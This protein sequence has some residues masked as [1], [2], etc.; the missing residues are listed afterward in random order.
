MRRFQDAWEAVDIDEI[1]A[2]LAGDAVLT[3]PPGARSGT[4][5]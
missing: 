2:L 1:V 5:A 4:T 3:M